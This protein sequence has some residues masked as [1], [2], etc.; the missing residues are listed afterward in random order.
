MK[1]SVRILGHAVHPMLVVFPLGL[2]TT[3]VVFDVIHYATGDWLWS[4][5][6]FWTMTVGLIGGLAAALFGLMDWS[7]LPAGSRARH[8]GSRHAIVNAV[9]LVLFAVSW[10]IRLPAEQMNAAPNALAFVLSLV[11]LAFALV[12]GWL[13]GELVERFGISVLG[14]TNVDAPSSLSNEA[15]RSSWPGGT[16]MSA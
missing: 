6:S 1:D 13:G 16:G 3:S 12:G 14:R 10:I 15:D 8:I 5:I 11:G 9:V 4:T 7:A 2:L